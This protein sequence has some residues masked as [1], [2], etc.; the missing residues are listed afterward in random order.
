MS[1]VLIG[2]FLPS[3]IVGAREEAVGRFTRL[4]FASVISLTVAGLLTAACFARSL[5]GFELSDFVPPIIF[6][7]DATKVWP[8]HGISVCWEAEYNNFPDEK[9]WVKDSVHQLIEANSNYRFSGWNKRCDK[10]D[11]QAVRISVADDWPKTDIGYDPTGPAGPTFSR[12]NFKFTSWGSSCASHNIGPDHLSIR[13][14]CIRTIA[15][16][17]MLHALGALHEQL[18][19]D[20]KNK[21]PDCYRVYDPILICENDRDKCGQHPMAL[22]AYD[23]DSIMNYCRNGASGNFYDLPLQ[24]S[25]GDMDGLTQLSGKTSMMELLNKA[26]LLKKTP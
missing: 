3:N 14:H 17:E 20:L 23:H 22:T 12:L 11:I 24:L 16:H 9:N 21:D 13:E 8:T 2:T 18:D 7:I 6:R 10:D 25:K 19:P 1:F 15:V 5:F 26:P 4:S